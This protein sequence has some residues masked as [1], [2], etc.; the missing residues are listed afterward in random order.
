MQVETQAS[1]QNLTASV[2]DSP[3]ITSQITYKTTFGVDNAANSETIYIA[4]GNKTD[5]LIAME[6]GA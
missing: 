5:R 3:L 6:V 4:W 1:T 2:L